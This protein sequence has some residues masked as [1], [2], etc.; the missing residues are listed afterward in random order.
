MGRGMMSVIRTAILAV[1]FPCGTPG[2]HGRLFPIGGLELHPVNASLY[3]AVIPV[4]TPFGHI[5]MHIVQAPGICRVGADLCSPAEIRPFFG[6]F[7]RAGAIVIRQSAAHLVAKVMSC[8]RSGPAGECPFHGGWKTVFVSVRQFAGL[9]L[10]LGKLPAEFTRLG[11]ID[12]VYR[13]PV[14]STGIEP[15]T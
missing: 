13:K 10:K 1:G 8:Q 2:H 7:Q 12:A 14:A 9:A 11:V 15:S 3:F 4:H 6:A 5:P